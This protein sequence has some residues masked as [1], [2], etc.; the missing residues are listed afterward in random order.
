MPTCTRC[1][2]FLVLDHGVQFAQSMSCQVDDPMPSSR[3]LN[4]GDVVDEVILRNRLAQREAA[5]MRM[6]QDLLVQTF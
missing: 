5:F 4:C 6:Q 3:C 1:G 2:G